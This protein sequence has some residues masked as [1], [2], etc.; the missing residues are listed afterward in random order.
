MSV[1]E[2]NVKFAIAKIYSLANEY[3]IDI[4]MH[5]VPVKSLGTRV[6]VWNVFFVLSM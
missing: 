5:T 4:Y 6:S 3:G 2:M 1:G